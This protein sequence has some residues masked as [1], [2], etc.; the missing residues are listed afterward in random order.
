MLCTGEG[1][2]LEKAEWVLGSL[3]AQVQG[4]LEVG[5]SCTEGEAP[6]ATLGGCNKGRI[7]KFPYKRWKVRPGLLETESSSPA[8]K[9]SAPGN[10]HLSLLR[11]TVICSLFL[12][13]PWP[14]HMVAGAWLLL[15]A[16]WEMRTSGSVRD[17]D[18]AEY[19]GPLTPPVGA[20]SLGWKHT[21]H[22]ALW[23]FCGVWGRMGSVC[24]VWSRE[25]SGWM[26]VFNDHGAR[27]RG[28][29]VPPISQNL[30]DAQ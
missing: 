24:L 1:G 21:P 28:A 15:E 12:R 30:Q 25:E 23:I 6:N 14:G 27:G 29:S 8:T 13:P 22:R 5:L 3:V 9:Y 4:V 19:T 7:G 26:E 18:R 10:P 17:S 16:L 2:G 11:A 20:Q